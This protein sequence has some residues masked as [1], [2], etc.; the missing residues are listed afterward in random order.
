ML[1]TT[2]KHTHSII[3]YPAPPP[4]ILPDPFHTLCGMP[5]LPHVEGLS[6]TA[7]QKLV[8]YTKLLE[9]EANDTRRVRVHAPENNTITETNTMETQGSTQ[10]LRLSKDKHSPGDHHTGSSRRRHPHRDSVYYDASPTNSTSNIDDNNNN[11]DTNTA[12]LPTTSRSGTTTSSSPPPQQPQPH[13]PSPAASL[14]NQLLLDKIDALREL[15]LGSLVSLPQLV[16]VGDQSSGKSSVLESLT[17][18]SFPRATGLCTRYATQITCRREAEAVA[19]AG[20]RRVEVSIIPRPGAHDALKA[21]LRAFRR[22]VE[23][24]DGNQLAGIFEEVRE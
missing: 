10:P 3:S 2:T 14:A 13:H 11:T 12:G 23:D 22:S 4:R 1:D 21:R 8:D 9:T 17:G 15:R 18:F 6:H 7:L 16:V 20:K 19:G 24:L 5:S